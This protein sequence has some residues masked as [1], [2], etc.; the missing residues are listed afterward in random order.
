MNMQLLHISAEK[1]LEKFGA[2]DHKPGSG[3]AAAFQGMISAK[4][5]VTVISLTNEKKRRES[6]SKSLPKLL[7]MGDD[8]QDRIYPELT[9]L[10]QEDSNQF[11]KAIKLRIARDNEKI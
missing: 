5:L 6:Y 4:L 2:G 3:S 10:F 9:N 1:L 11:D 8:I 7:K